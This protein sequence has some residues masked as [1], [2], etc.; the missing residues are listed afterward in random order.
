M[1]AYLQVSIMCGS[2]DF[3]KFIYLINL[4]QIHIAPLY[5]LSDTANLVDTSSGFILKHVACIYDQ[6]LK[7][8]YL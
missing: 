2:L 7:P 8:L 1:N 4:T 6:M 3:L 5:L